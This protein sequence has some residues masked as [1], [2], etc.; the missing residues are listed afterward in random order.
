MIKATSE[1]NC[2]NDEKE[3][4]IF[5]RNVFLVLISKFFLL[6]LLKSF[7]IKVSPITFHLL[8]MTGLTAHT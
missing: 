1:G 3:F 2:R 4:L 5:E 7:F 8:S 6:Y